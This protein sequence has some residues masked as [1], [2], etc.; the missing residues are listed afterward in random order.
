MEGS[1]EPKAQH[2]ARERAK[3]GITHTFTDDLA[4]LPPDQQ[5]VRA[6]CYHP[7]APSTRSLKKP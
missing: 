6:K 3:E 7:T 5:R 2:S 4:T 1:R